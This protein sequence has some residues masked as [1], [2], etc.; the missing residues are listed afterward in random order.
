MHCTKY[1]TVNF[2]WT[3]YLS[4]MNVPFKLINH[5][6]KLVIEFLLSGIKNRACKG[7]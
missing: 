5:P 2:I 7:V 1:Q 6:R 4:K 3:N